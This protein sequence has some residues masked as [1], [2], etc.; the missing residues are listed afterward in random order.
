MMNTV[1]IPLVV[2]LVTV[3]NLAIDF[4]VMETHVKVSLDTV[5]LVFH[6][7]HG[8]VSPSKTLAQLPPPPNYHHH[9]HHQIKKQKKKTKNK[10]E[11]RPIYRVSFKILIARSY[12]LQIVFVLVDLMVV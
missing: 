11:S 4:T 6:P 10:G 8:G 5:T 9:H 12:R 7:L 3:L 2:I 1:T